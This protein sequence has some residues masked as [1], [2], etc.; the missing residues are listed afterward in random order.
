MAMT[1]P[2]GA[3]PPIPGAMPPKKGRAAPAA[4]TKGAPPKGLPKMKK[5][6]TKC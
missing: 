2:F 1:P 6:K 5:G 3:G 4:K